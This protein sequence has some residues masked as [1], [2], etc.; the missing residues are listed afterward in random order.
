MTCR[1]Q[2]LKAEARVCAAAGWSIDLAEIKNGGGKGIVEDS[3]GAC[4]KY[5][6][7]SATQ[8]FRVWG[9]Y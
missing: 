4:T 7:R 6:L 3:R 2:K 9:L 5:P 8:L 1:V